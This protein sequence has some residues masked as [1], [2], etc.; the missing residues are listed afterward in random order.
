VILAFLLV[1]LQQTEAAAAAPV[2]AARAA[3]E[4]GNPAGALVHV[5]RALAF[6]P[7]ALPVLELGL[8]AATGDD[9]ARALWS[10]DWWAAASDATGRARPAGAARDLLDA[11]DP[12][13]ARVAAARA[14]AVDEL[15]AFAEARQKRGRKAPEELLVARWARRLARE[16]ARPAPALADST[17]ELSP[18]LVLPAR[19]YAPVIRTLQNVLN[20]ALSNRD[21]ALAMRAAR[22]LRG[23]GAQSDF[24]D[25][26]GPEPK[27]MKN[28]RGAA[29]AG[30]A[31]AREQ[32]A[33]AA[34]EPWTVEQLEWLSD[35]EGEVFTR[36]HDS[37]ANPGLAVSPRGWYR[38]ETDC[39]YQT[40]LGVA[41]TIELHHERLANWYGA[42]PFEGRPG[43]C[44]VVPEAT[45]L[46]AE[47][48]PFWWVG[49]FQGGDVTTLRF[50]TGNIE[51]FGHG[52][53]HELTHRFDG[54]LYPGQPAWLSEG[55]AVWTA[56]SY[57]HSSDARFVANKVAFGTMQGALGKGYGGADKL[58]E[59]IEGT[60][61]DYRDNYVAGY[62]LY[63]YLQLWEEGGR[64][65]FR[66]RLRTFMEDAERG[67]DDWLA[68]F[69]SLFCDGE[70]GRPED[71]DGFAERFR[72]FLAGFD[73]RDRAPFTERFTESID[74]RGDDWVYDE[75][76]WG[77]QRTRAEPVF[78]EGLAAIAGGVLLDA[79]RRDEGIRALVWALG[80]DGPTPRTEAR[81]EQALEAAGEDAAVWALAHD[82][83]ER[84][85]AAGTPPP[86]DNFLPRTRALLDA[87]DAAADAYGERGLAR[88]SAAMVADCD[89]L[90]AHL[91]RAPCGAS[92]APPV[93]GAPVTVAGAPVTVAAAPAPL[94]R[95]DTPPR[96]L[97]LTGWEE[98]GLTGYEERRVS[99][100]WYVDGDQHLHL[101][102]QRPRE[103]TGR[104]D[105][106]A[107]QRDVYV[108]S[109]EWLEPGSYRVRTRVRFTTSYAA[110][111]VVLGATRRDRGVRVHFSAGNF[112]YAIGES[113]DEPT[114]EEVD[115]R[116][117][118]LRER[119]GGLPGS[120][121]RGRHG[122]DGSRTAFDLE[123]LVDGGTVRV[124]IDDKRVGA[125]HTVDGTPVEGY[126]GFAVGTGAVQVQTPT[127]ERLDRARLAGTGVIP[128]GLDLVRQR[129]DPFKQL[130]N[131]TLRG[132]DVPPQGALLLWIPYPELDEGEELDLPKLVNRVRLGTKSLVRFLNKQD[133]TQPFR[134][135]VPRALGEAGIAEL[136]AS[137]EK[138]LVD[139]P[140]LLLHDFLP[141]ESPDVG[142]RW[143]FFVD[144]AGVI[145]VAAP[146]S[147][148]V[149]AFGDRLEHW[150]TV[151]RDHG[152]PAR[153]LPSLERPA[154]EEAEEE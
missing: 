136:Q 60:I 16:L 73:W 96:H 101:G 35:E 129:A 24:K 104:L 154:L 66:D 13:P 64:P 149:A 112:L 51:G 25:L 57:G 142:K 77:W 152:R 88:A 89:R 153:D 87:L 9:D 12:H 120:V 28:V 41:R 80:C 75:P 22:V 108:R 8:A 42:D 58:A 111:V 134:I 53:T 95:F 82:R 113:D 15:V 107:H 17:A 14:L 63:V 7:F 79:G 43:I 46:E 148:Q 132:L 68:F 47:G 99:D 69:E 61:E 123:V 150:M 140:E 102:R 151:F 137:F 91:G 62:A 10:H 83:W 34:G 81:L 119:D 141:P 76:T 131:R 56:D 72:T 50:S 110:G 5:E 94:H 127:V 124:S 4:A 71:L 146:F 92:V 109:R 100:F 105:R 115:W 90:A 40:L 117:D 37:F 67:R 125:Y 139:P 78:G 27:G 97:G 126:V 20:H 52:L 31:R 114:F 18:E 122:F 59:L 33:A 36:E 48:A 130:A 30:L 39:G 116:I 85:G 121:A 11:D 106:A 21:T 103:G 26:Q 65:L 147:S 44:R 55:K 45:G 138:L 135:A 145:R 74:T 86:F 54:A 2:A 144:P 133:A 19:T 98:D 6:G 93:A 49:G 3:L 1:T 84:S 128:L 29:E 70:D 38:V 118:G 23:L 143:L 32:L